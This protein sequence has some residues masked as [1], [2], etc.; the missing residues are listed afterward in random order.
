[1]PLKAAQDKAKQE[2]AAELAGKLAHRVPNGVLFEHVNL[3]DSQSG[4][5]LKDQ[6]VVVAGNRIVKVGPSDQVTPPAGSEVIN[7]AGPPCSFQKSPKIY[8]VTYARG[9]NGIA[10]RQAGADS[11]RV[12]ENDFADMPMGSQPNKSSKLGAKLSS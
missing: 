10:C 1:M 5:I 6:S 7:A 9:W 11:K 12:I 8:V 3:F 2:R 4:E